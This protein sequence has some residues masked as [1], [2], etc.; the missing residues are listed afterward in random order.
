MISLKELVRRHFLKM[1]TPTQTKEN[2]Q[3]LMDKRKELQVEAARAKQSAAELEVKIHKNKGDKSPAMLESKINELEK[4]KTF[5]TVENKNSK[6]N[7]RQG[8]E[9]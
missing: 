1:N 5:Y 6:N 2:I 4:M 3:R 7:L 9:T 8:K